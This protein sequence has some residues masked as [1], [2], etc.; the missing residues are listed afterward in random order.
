MADDFAMHKSDTVEMHI[1]NVALV[2]DVGDAADH[3]TLCRIQHLLSRV[4]PQSL[5]QW[6]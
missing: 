5:S 6:R 1:R 2:T 4:A 3:V